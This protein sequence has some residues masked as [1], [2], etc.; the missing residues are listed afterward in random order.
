MNKRILYIMNVDWDWI[1]QRP[2]FLAEELSKEF[3]V[4][5]VQPINYRR[6]NLVKD[7]N[8][9]LKLHYWFQLPFGRF[10]IIRKINKVLMWVYF[11]FFIDIKQYEVVWLTTPIYYPAIQSLISLNQKVIYDCMDDNAVFPGLPS[12]LEFCTSEKQLV[13]RADHLF[14]S[15]NYLM[16]VI[17]K[18]Y[19]ICDIEKATIVNNALIPGMVACEEPKEENIKSMDHTIHITYIGTI[20]SWLDFKLLEKSLNK[21]PNIQFELYGPIEKGV[22]YN[23]SRVVCHGPIPHND[24]IKVMQESDALIMPFQLIPLV[25]SVNPVKLYEYI[26]SM[27]PI[28]CVSY[29]ETQAFEK[30]VYSYHNDDECL[31]LINDLVNGKLKFKS[32]REEVNKFLTENTWDTRG[33]EVRN[34]L[35]AL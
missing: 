29:K 8:R 1:K 30:F 10:S 33:K 27:K 21:F 3:S 34:I 23:H 18:R 35:L 6:H 4:D 19:Q 14:F 5:V 17:L 26:S 15:S 28:I 2:Q 20:A 32:T 9:K 13:S 16:D 31:A 22:E 11:K 24:V 12:A 7:H 25:M